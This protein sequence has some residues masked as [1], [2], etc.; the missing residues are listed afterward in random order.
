MTYN[1]SN[2][3]SSV[4]TLSDH[5]FL[6]LKVRPW[7]R[8]LQFIYWYNT[9]HCLLRRITRLVCTFWPDRFR[10]SHLYRLHIWFLKRIH[11]IK[12]LK[13]YRGY[14]FNQWSSTQPTY[15]FMKQ[16]VICA[17]RMVVFAKHD[18][19]CTTNCVIL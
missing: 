14:V 8:Y 16:T 15:G 10:G 13:R 12:K 9:S 19:V 6:Y 5:I 1:L 3:I 2:K 17:Q 11:G 4:S 7:L 18:A